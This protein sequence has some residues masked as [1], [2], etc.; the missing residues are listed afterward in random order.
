[1]SRW[2]YL[3]FVSLLFCA[4]CNNNNELKMLVGPY[5]VTVDRMDLMGQPNHTP[6][7]DVMSISIG[8]NSTMLLLFETGIST[9]PGGPNP[10]GLI[11]TLD[12]MNVKLDTQPANVDYSTGA[13]MGTLV[14]TGTIA[15][16][17]STVSLDLK[18]VPSN[19][20]LPNGL[21]AFDYTVA[22]NKS[23]M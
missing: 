7:T 17:G 5:A 15:P 19:L 11:A 18:V 16:D 9:D 2:L 20:A 4:G 23:Q 13:Y 3:G 12:G 1:M 10:N 8:R 6:D 22:G 14:G 21:T